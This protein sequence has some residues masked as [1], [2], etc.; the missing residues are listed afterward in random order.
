M[1]SSAVSKVCFAAMTAFA[2]LLLVS[3]AADGDALEQDRAQSSA[4][5]D[6]KYRPELD[7][8]L[9]ADGRQIAVREC[10]SCH[11]I[12]DQRVSP[13]AEAPPMMSLLSR[14]DPEMLTDDLIEGIRVGH[15]DMPHFD[16]D[17]RAADAL[18][19]YLK[20]IERPAAS[21]ER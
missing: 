13:R 19:A 9:A 7:P 3:C 1:S 16:F 18:V 17:I 4:V 8:A 10:S 5:V 15:D 2:S 11:A 14:Y 6:G 21:T 12:D 20:S